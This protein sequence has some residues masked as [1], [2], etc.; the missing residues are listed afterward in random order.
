MDNNLETD[1]EQCFL[2]YESFFRGRNYY[3]ALSN[4]GEILDAIQTAP[5]SFRNK[6]HERLKSVQFSDDI[7]D[8][9]RADL[10]VSVDYF[11]RLLSIHSVPIYENGVLVLT[12]RIEIENIISAM[13]FIVGEEVDVDLASLD[14][15]LE[16][17]LTTHLQLF[18]QAQSSIIKHARLPTTN[19]WVVSRI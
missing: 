1:I 13:R 18:R 14:S 7:V 11:L 10:S 15:A 16:A 2:E 3:S 19:R 12:K 6:W 4:L 5:A 8:I 9:V 17:R